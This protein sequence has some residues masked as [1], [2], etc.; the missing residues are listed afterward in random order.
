MSPWL[1]STRFWPPGERRIQIEPPPVLTTAVSPRMG[2]GVRVGV[3][4]TV[5]V[6]VLVG[7]ADG[8]GEG[9]RVSP[10]GG[11]VGVRLGAA[12]VSAE[13]VAALPGSP[14]GGVSVVRGGPPK[15][16]VTGVEG[17]LVAPVGASSTTSP[18][19]VGS[20]LGVLSAVGAWAAGS[21]A[22]GLSGTPATKKPMASSSKAKAYPVKARTRKSRREPLSPTRLIKPGDCPI[23]ARARASSAPSAET[24]MPHNVH[25]GKP[26]GLI[27]TI[28]RVRC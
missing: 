12:G 9:V 5:G 8:A 25:S 10:A 26:I 13:V 16:P 22:V 2:V 15:A 19:L 24:L 1:T 17:V 4:V 14:V 3:G 28:L 21:S 18:T 6:G 23:K 20:E 11:C 7:V 27:I